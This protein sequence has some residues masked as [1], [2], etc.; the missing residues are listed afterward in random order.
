MRL[1]E[2]VLRIVIQNLDPSGGLE[3]PQT[4]SSLCL[5]SKLLLE[6]AR[7]QL[8][9]TIRIDDM[10]CAQ[11]D[12]MM[13]MF[14]LTSI[15]VDEARKAQR[16]RWMRVAFRRREYDI[17]KENWD[18]EQKLKEAR[19]ERK[20][21]YFKKPDIFD[22]E[23]SEPEDNG[24]EDLP[25]RDYL[26]WGP[27]DILDPFSYQ[28]LLSL[29]AHPHL[30]QL[31]K[32]IDFHGRLEGKPTSIIVERF[33]I[34]CPNIE[35]ILL[36]RGSVRSLAVHPR[37]A[38]VIVKR[39]RNLKNLEVIDFAEMGSRTLFKKLSKL[40]RLSHLSLSC[41]NSRY[42][43]EFSS[44]DFSL[45]SL[46]TRSL[47]SLHL[48]SLFSPDFFESIPSRFLKSITSLGIAVRRETPDLSKFKSLQHLTITYG[49]TSH[50]V[51]ALQ[52]LSSINEIKSLEL[53][54][55]NPLWRF[56]FIQRRDEREYDYDYWGSA[57]DEDEDEDDNDE[58]DDEEEGEQGGGRVGL[59]IP[60]RKVKTERELD[61]LVDLFDHL[62]PKI[63][64]LSIPSLLTEEEEREFTQAVETK[65]PPSLKKISLLREGNDKEEGG[66]G[67]VCSD[68]N[69]NSYKARRRAEREE[70]KRNPVETWLDKVSKYLSEEKGV[71]VFRVQHWTGGRSERSL[72]SRLP[73]IRRG[74]L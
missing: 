60:S 42:P 66:G 15:D 69:E 5:T 39:A 14:E 49:Y 56:E 52:T 26:D 65:L 31:V 32:A 64:T 45:A 8:Y 16:S 40:P 36:Y 58:S 4:L 20:G 30:A 22:E 1:P 67:D 11:D 43:T 12:E 33:L 48:G 25:E 62:P 34:V 24:D 44:V 51:E 37:V 53:R 73:S 50:A 46:S 29:E 61:S 68:E 47:T 13:R 28:Q 74:P 18:A 21:R 3:G 72:L 17:M 55:S 57:D 9:S 6:L 71:E 23:E 19:G 70:R 27:T 35:T 10:R 41:S 59:A 63:E 2:D 38:Q 7:P 54:T